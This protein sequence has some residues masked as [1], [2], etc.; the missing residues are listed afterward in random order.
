MLNF[1]GYIFLKRFRFVCVFCIYVV[2]LSIFFLG[3]NSGRFFINIILLIGY[4]RRVRGESII[5]KTMTGHL[6]IREVLVFN[7]LLKPPYF[8]WNHHE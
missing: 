3:K 8:H 2:F 6:L 4:I 7:L 5:Q 1:F